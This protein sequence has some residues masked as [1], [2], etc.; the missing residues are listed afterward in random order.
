M[1]EKL[2]DE[3]KRHEDLRGVVEASLVRPS[4]SEKMSDGLV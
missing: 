3:Q 2:D 1:M 4:P